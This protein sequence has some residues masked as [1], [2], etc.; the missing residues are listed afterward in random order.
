MDIRRNTYAGILLAAVLSAMLLA[1]CRA[2]EPETVIVNKAP[3]TFIIGAPLEHGGGYY[4]FHVFWYG[5]DEDGSVERFV[6]A[7]TDTSL[8]DPDTTTDEEDQNFNPALDATTLE[9][10]RWTTRT[11]SV[12]NFTINQGVR[13][14]ADMTLHMVAVDDFGDFDRTPARLHFFSNT[15]GNPELRFFRITN[16]DTN[17]GSITGPDTIAIRPGVADTV[18]YGVQYNLYWTGTSPNIRG[19][20]PEALALVDTVAP[21]DDGLCGYKW[22]IMGDLGGNCLP[23]LQDCWSPRS[24][25]EAT[26][27]SFSFFGSLTNLVFRNNGSGTSPYRKYLPSGAVN[28]EVNSVDIAGVEV[29]QHLRSF[30]FVVN[31]DPETIILDGETDWAHPSD[32][33]IYP[34]YIRLNDPNKIHYPFRSHERSPDRTYVVFKALARDDL[35]DGVLDQDFKIGFTGFVSGTVDIFTGGRFTF[36]TDASE[37]NYRPTWDALCDT[38]WYA[39]TLGFLTNPST[40]FTIN[41]QAVDEHERRDG[42]P[43][44]I[45][46]DVGYPPC[47]QCIE[48]L[49]KTSLTS[50]WGPSLACVD[51]PATHPCFQDVTELRVALNPGPDDLEYRQDTFMLVDKQTY[52]VRYSDSSTGFEATN[53]VIPAKIYTMSVLLHGIDDAREAWAEPVRRSLGWS[54]QIDYECDPFNQIQD[55]GGNDDIK[56]PTWGEAVGLTIDTASGL[57]RLNV[58]VVVPSNLFFGEDTYRFLLDFTQSGGDPEIT[59]AIFDA[60]TRQ[61]GSGTVKAMAMDQTACGSKPVRPGQYSYFRNVRPSV[62]E[63]PGAVTWRDCGLEYTI[64]GIKSGFTLTL[65]VMANS[66]QSDAVVKHFRLVVQTDA[67]DFTCTLP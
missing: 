63:L 54:Y 13:F 25:N 30:E 4:H 9:I 10:G 58:D 57:W 38:C 12:F 27:D 15:L 33:E 5:S 51:D 65:G 20:S 21:Y 28:L 23:S 66:K 6:W 31:F 18:G 26:G 55:G 52:F 53:Y 48:L 40:E 61:F 35:R 39:D 34:Y 47:L 3:E 43:A 29:A 11:D 44:N 2:F 22:R 67:G 37:V 8:Q 16:P 14:S 7:L 17:N 56:S 60:T 42:S 45:S 62:A 64:P 50:A 49:P 46:F 41:M 36:G 32:T 19:Y 59:Q 1:G 24:F